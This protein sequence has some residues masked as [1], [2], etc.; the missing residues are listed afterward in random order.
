MTDAL[1][2]NIEL[3][4]KNCSELKEKFGVKKI[5]IFGSFARDEQKKTSDI[6]ILVE[7]EK[8]IGIF[9]FLDL[10]EYLSKLLKRKVD[11]V[12]KKAIKK[13]IQKAVLKE[14][15]YV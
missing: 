3:I 13:T 15:I 5:G 10:E 14:T 11:L 4:S 12:T 8:P 1:L 6:D 9:Q 7:L 2:K